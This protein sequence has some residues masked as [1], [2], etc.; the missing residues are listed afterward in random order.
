MALGSAT[1][2]RQGTRPWTSPLL[3]GVRESVSQL[4][5]ET[6]QVIAPRTHWTR[7]M[8]RH[9]PI[10][11]LSQPAARPL[12]CVDGVAIVQRCNTQPCLAEV[13]LAILRLL[14]V[15]DHNSRV[16]HASQWRIAISL[17]WLL[18]NASDSHFFLLSGGYE[19]PNCGPISP[20]LIGCTCFCRL[21]AA[22]SHRHH[23][24]LP[25][26]LAGLPSCYALTIKPISIFYLHPLFPH[27]LPPP[28]S[29]S[30]PLLF[31]P[32]LSSHHSFLSCAL[33]TPSSSLRFSLSLLSICPY[34]STHILY[35][36]AGV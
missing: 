17:V 28:S 30:R 8:S 18:Y 11:Y 20:P 3:V 31:T 6:G 35:S 36:A 33:P 14:I 21:L 1:S 4:K 23:H 26:C 7:P 19:K 22:S 5:T 2:V 9:P 15:Q 32:P 13:G 12:A 16:S 27:S 25:S 29:P 10:S 34:P 24:F